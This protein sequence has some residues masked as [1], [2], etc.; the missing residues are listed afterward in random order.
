MN[1]P[2][3]ASA[4]TPDALPAC[5]SNSPPPSEGSDDGY[6]ELD[7]LRRSPRPEP[8]PKPP[9]SLT[10]GTSMPGSA[11]SGD[12]PN[13]EERPLDGGDNEFLGSNAP[14]T[15]SE[16]G[17]NA[18]ES[19]GIALTEGSPQQYPSL[20]DNMDVDV[21]DTTG[22][23]SEEVVDQEHLASVEDDITSNEITEVNRNRA[24]PEVLKSRE[25]SHGLEVSHEDS[26]SFLSETGDATDQNK[27][28]D[29]EITYMTPSPVRSPRPDNFV[30]LLTPPVRRS[31]MI[32]AP[33][34]AASLE[35]S[36]IFDGPSSTP[37]ATPVPV[38]PTQPR[39]Q[40]NP[41]YTIPPFKLLH[42]DTGRKIKS[43]KQRKREKN[44][45]RKDS[46]W[47]PI[48]LNRW[49]A[50]VNANPVWKKVSRA[51][52]CLS[53]REWAVCPYIAFHEFD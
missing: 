8:K 36:Y 38:S 28:P 9:R 37:P 20:P 44:E 12:E 52:K 4:I 53:T 11:L 31:I 18:A 10:A 30:T 41:N 24:T 49:A 35:P 7:L 19:D 13:T 27:P 1:Q 15:M 39:H 46:E 17:L 26:Q 22:N 45:G 3:P 43:T 40:Y 51:S 23:D 21:P 16:S 33:T 14:L 25:A 29:Q 32:P 5:H 34:F 42:P 47:A 48:G 6:D 2:P 50:T